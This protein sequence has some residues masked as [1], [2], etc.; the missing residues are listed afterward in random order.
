MLGG[1]DCNAAIPQ[2]EIGIRETG[3]GANLRFPP[4]PEMIT[5]LGQ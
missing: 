3:L 5:V 2:D 1:R 4:K